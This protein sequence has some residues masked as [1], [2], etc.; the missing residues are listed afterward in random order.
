[1]IS[2]KIIDKFKI[3]CKIYKAPKKTCNRKSLYKPLKKEKKKERNLI[4]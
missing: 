1:M 4:F 3:K 2:N